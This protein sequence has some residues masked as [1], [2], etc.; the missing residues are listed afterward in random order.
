MARQRELRVGAA[1]PFPVVAHPDQ[2]LAAVLQL[3]ADRP[4]TGVEGVLQKLL[5][6]RRRP[7]DDFPRGDLVG[8]LRGQDRDL[9]RRERGEG[10]GHSRTTSE[11]STQPRTPSGRRTASQS[12]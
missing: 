7:L 6:D 1:H 9:G 12:P 2:G 3:D 11:P 4:G 5:H 8:D 10:W